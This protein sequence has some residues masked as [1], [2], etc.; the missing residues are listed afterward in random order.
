M[1][2]MWNMEGEGVFVMR[3]THV[4]HVFGKLCIPMNTLPPPVPRGQLRLHTDSLDSMQTA[5]TVLEIFLAEFR[6][7][8]L[9]QVQAQS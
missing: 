8:V 2:N 9:F 4:R 7:K 3:Q 6:A 1:L 5:R